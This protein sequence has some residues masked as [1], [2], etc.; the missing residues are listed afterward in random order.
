[1]LDVKGI[2]GAATDVPALL[3]QMITPPEPAALRQGAPGATLPAC[4]CLSRPAAA[5][6]GVLLPPGLL[7]RSSGLLPHARHRRRR[8]SNACRSVLRPCRLHAPAAITSLRL[9]GALDA[10]DGALTALGQHLTRMPCDPRIG[11]PALPGGG[12]C[13]GR[14]LGGGS[15]GGNG[16]WWAAAGALP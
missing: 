13:R 7:R 9:I 14:Q 4:C 12:S 16:G 8:G 1:M 3:A 15:V 5:S 11:A 2:L 6:A 10:S